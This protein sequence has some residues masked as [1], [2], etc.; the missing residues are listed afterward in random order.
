MCIRDR[1][2]LLGRTLLLIHEHALTS[3]SRCSYLGQSPRLRPTAKA[4]AIRK[5]LRIHHTWRSSTQIHD[6][7]CL[8]AGGHFELKL[9]IAFRLPASRLTFL[10]SEGETSGSHGDVACMT[11]SYRKPRLKDA[12][13]D[14]RPKSFGVYNACRPVEPGKRS[15]VM[16]L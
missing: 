5:N 12:T 1:S 4:H 15:K 13:R 7:S 6:M 16:R 3:S 9:S 10:V 11:G 2:G 8:K 14:L